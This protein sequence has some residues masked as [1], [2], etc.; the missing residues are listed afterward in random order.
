MALTKERENNND[1]EMI[2]PNAIASREDLYN[3]ASS[4]TH[5]NVDMSI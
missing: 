5:D 3:T 4:E 2:I 1:D